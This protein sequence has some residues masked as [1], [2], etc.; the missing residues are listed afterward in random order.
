MRWLKF[1][2]R[3]SP[4]PRQGERRCP[5]QVSPA[6]PSA[7]PSAVA[8][9]RPDPI[10][11]GLNPEQREA[12]QHPGGPLLILAGAGSGKTRVIT[13]RIAYL[14]SRRNL[15]P[16]QIL[17]VTFTNKAATE[18]RSRVVE[19]VGGQVAAQVR[20]GTF[21][22]TCLRIL[23]RF[24]E[25][26]GLRPNF[27]IYDEADQL[28][29]VKACLASLTLDGNAKDARAI[30]QQI[31]RAKN[32][33]VTPDMLRDAQP[34]DEVTARFLRV[35]AEY[36]D[37]LTFAN[38]VDF[39]DLLLKAVRMFEASPEI[40]H[41][42]RRAWHH[43]FVDE[44]QDTNLAQYQLIKL[45]AAEH[46]NVCVVGDD[47]QAIYTWR[48][49][50]ISNI[51][52]FRR[53]YPDCRIVTLG[54]NY[55][56]TKRILA[57]AGALIGHNRQ[58]MPKALHTDNPD[59]DP[60]Q[61]HRA[62]D[63]NAQATY[64]SGWIRHLTTVGGY[65]YGDVGVL[66]RIHA[67]S[68]ALEV[69]LRRALIPCMIVGVTRFYDRKEIKDALAYLRIMRNPEDDLA[70]CRI[71][72]VP[73][74]GIGPSTIAS[75]SARARAER[76]SLWAVCQDPDA[77]SP[78]SSKSRAAVAAF[79]RLVEELR[80]GGMRCGVAPLL[81]AVLDRTGYLRE[82][83]GDKSDEAGNRADNLQELIASA[84]TFEA[85]TEEPTLSAFLDETA[86]LS[87]I[88]TAP[89]GPGAVTLMTLHS[90]K[91]LEF[92]VVFLVGTEE[93][94]LP[95]CRALEAPTGLEE[96][97]RLCYVG[98]TRAKRQLFLSLS[99]RR[100][101]HR[102]DRVSEPS[103]FLQEIPPAHLVMS[104]VGRLERYTPTELAAVS[105]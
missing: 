73:A 3:A 43:L 52:D 25:A 49:A 41:T 34:D 83:E 65:A 104:G 97:R 62:E 5:P 32:R 9:Q 21:H 77:R 28:A 69:T 24:P 61:L 78:L 42:Y 39:D 10:L 15:D 87:D 46:R 44:Y 100:W 67:Q 81:E 30:L 19:L 31:G 91:G 27:S 14:I 84:R 94:L 2:Q 45:L 75:L 53:D 56:S 57:V 8:A 59:G 95:H 26:A 102:E 58:R 68:R 35:Y 79:V 37:R 105:D 98:M 23:R 51:L 64:V 103:C 80:S 86:M 70:L 50:D 33:L 7:R 12:V 63:E 29:L 72:N 22:A 36:Q 18:M 82:L 88:D 6:G 38:G 60:V 96:E 4:A 54:Q 55:R 101:V 16:Q 20:L 92:P 17:A 66:Y 93:G 11:R 47:D 99:A 85:E 13:H 90:A 40:L 74:R 89:T 76:R 1:W 48:G 71:L